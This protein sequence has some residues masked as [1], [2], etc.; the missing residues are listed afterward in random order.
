MS[1]LAGALAAI[2]DDLTTDGSRG[3]YRA[4]LSALLRPA[5]QDVGWSPAPDET[6]DTQ[7]LR[8]TLVTAL[9]D[10]AR[11][12]DVLAKA[13]ASWSSRSW[14]SPA[15]SSRRCST[16]S[17]PSRRDRET[18]RSTTATSRAAS[19]RPIRTSAIGTSTR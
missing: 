3:K 7:A 10:T 15:P 13:R 19:R 9:G 6:D 5:L 1:T 16:P 4:W 18:P 14:T 2:G 8:A 11:D 17:S 12:P